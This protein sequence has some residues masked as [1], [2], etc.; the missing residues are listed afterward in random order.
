[1]GAGL[2]LGQRVA[3][4]RLK[5]P[6]AISAASILRPV[7]LMRSPMMQNGRSKPITTS[8]VAELTTVSVMM[9]SSALGAGGAGYARTAVLHD[10]GAVDDLRD[11]LFLAIGHDVHAGDAVDLADLLDQLDAEL[12]A[13]AL[14]V[15]GALEPGDD[16]RRG[17]GTPGTLPRIQRAVLAEASGPTPTRMKAF[18]AEP[19]VARLVHEAAQQRHVV[20]IL[21]LDE[22]RPGGD[23]LAHMQR[24]V[25]VG[26]RERVGGGADEDLRR[27]GDL[28]AGEEA[29]LV[30]HR[31]DGLE[32]RGGIEVED[33]LGAAAGRPPA[34]RRR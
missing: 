3:S 22:L 14:L 17:H 34:R 15:L 27:L 6:A 8:L 2:D 28:A 33:R 26:R 5:S 23:L 13:L 20:A 1:V 29:P 25:V 10:A 32:Q 19:E 4:T 21:R 31:P 9:R 7:G 16:R 18:S 11:E 24:P 12:L 30:A